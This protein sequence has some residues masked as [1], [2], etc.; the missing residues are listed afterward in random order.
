[1]IAVD[2][3]AARSVRAAGQAGSIDLHIMDNTGMAGSAAWVF[4]TA[5]QIVGAATADRVWASR[6][7]ARKSRNHVVTLSAGPV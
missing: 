5:E 3:P 7:K 1:L 2:D 4:D 6:V